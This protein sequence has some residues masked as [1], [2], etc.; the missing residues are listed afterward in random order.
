MKKCPFCAEEIQDEAIVCRYCGRSL[1]SKPEP[2]PT[3]ARKDPSTGISLLFGFLLLVA[4][5]GI[6]YFIA[7][8]WTGN[9]S[10]LKSTMTMYQAGAMFV[11]TLLA[12][13]GL[14]PDKRDF[15]RYVGIF[16]LSVIP[17]VGW[18]VIYWAGKGL[19]RSLIQ[20]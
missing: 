6:A 3:P 16:I 18:I 1:T 14:N 17:I 4:I 20:N 11:I 13:P 2:P 12:V 7:V 19:A 9:S 15:L 5:Y 10:D 8:N